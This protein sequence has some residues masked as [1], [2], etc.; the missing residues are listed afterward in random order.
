[1]VSD[2]LGWLAGDLG[3]SRITLIA[4]RGDLR[5]FARFLGDLPIHDAS[6]PPPSAAIGRTIPLEP[7]APV[8]TPSKSR[9]PPT[10]EHT[11][12]HH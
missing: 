7:R 3:V 8:P 6:T 10:E 2:F 4:Y 9:P 5:V 12:E 11:S 1:M